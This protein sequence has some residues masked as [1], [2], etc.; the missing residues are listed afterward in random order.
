MWTKRPGRLD[1]VEFLIPARDFS[2]AFDM[3]FAALEMVRSQW[4][5]AAR[6]N[7]LDEDS[8]DSLVESLGALRA[9]GKRKAGQLAGALVAIAKNLARCVETDS[10][11]EGNAALF[12]VDACIHFGKALLPRESMRERITSTVT[13][14]C[15]SHAAALGWRPESDPEDAVGAAIEAEFLAAWWRQVMAGS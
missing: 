11:P 2:Q 14:A 9:E 10:T 1:D 6:N 12:A 5:P 4:S 3:G 13:C 7:R 8:L 15:Q